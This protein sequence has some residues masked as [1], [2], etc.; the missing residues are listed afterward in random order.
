MEV[1]KM[2]IKGVVGK[3]IS[4]LT[5]FC[6]VISSCVINFFDITDNGI[7]VFEVNAADYSVSATVGIESKV[8]D[9]SA[10]SE[11]TT[12]TNMIT[13]MYGSVASSYFYKGYKK[14]YMVFHEGNKLYI[15][16]YNTSLKKLSS[17]TIDDELSLFGGFYSGEKYNFI[18]YGKSYSSTDKETYRVVKYDKNFNKIASLSI[19]GDKTYTSKPFKVCTSSFSE[20][21]N[22]LIIYTARLR[23]DGHQ[24]NITLR[25]NEEDMTISDEYDGAASYPVHHSGH[26]FRSIIKTDT[27][28]SEIYASLTDR[29][30]CCGVSVIK[31]NRDGYM[32]TPGISNV[33]YTEIEHPEYDPYSNIN[34]TDAEVNGLV[35]TDNSYV[36]TGVFYDNVFVGAVDKTTG[37][38]SKTMLT[39]Y[40]EYSEYGLAQESKLVQ[41]NRNESI[42]LWQ[43]IVD[44]IFSVHYAKVDAKGEI[45][46][47]IKTAFN[48]L[49]SD[50]QPIYDEG[51]IR[52]FTIVNGENTL[53]TISDTMFEGTFEALGSK[54]V[55]ADNIW[56]GT[57]DT[58][59]YN[60]SKN[61]FNISTAEQLAGLSEL[62]N[63]GNDMNGKRFVLTCDIYLNADEG[64]QVFTPIASVSSGVQ[65]SGIFDGNG[66][67]IYRLYRV[68]SDDSTEGGLFGTVGEYGVI[69]NLIIDQSYVRQDAGA[70]AA[71][72]Y[73]TIMFCE[74]M[75]LVAGTI[76]EGDNYVG[77]IVG[78]TYGMVYGC[79]NK[80]R[81]IGY[82]G[83]AGG[84]SGYVKTV[85]GCVKACY[86]SG[87]VSS[88][89][90]AAG[91]IIGQIGH[92]GTVEDCF[93]IGTILD[94]VTASST[95]NFAK[96]VGGIAGGIYDGYLVNC[97]ST[98]TLTKNKYYFNS[99]DPLCG[100]SYNRWGNNMCFDCYSLHNSNYGT[101][102]TLEEMLSDGFINKL[103]SVT[104]F[105]ETR[106]NDMWVKGHFL[107][108]TIAQKADE[109]N[110]HKYYP[111]ACVYK[112]EEH[113]GEDHFGYAKTKFSSN[114]ERIATVDDEGNITYHGGVGTVTIT[115]TIPETEVS[116]K[117]VHNF[118]F[119]KYG[120]AFK[121]EYETLVK[122]KTL[123]LSVEKNYNNTPSG[124]LSFSSDD[125]SIVTVSSTGLVKAISK[126]L[127]TITATHG[128][129]KT[130]CLIY[131][132]DGSSVYTSGK[133]GTNL[134]YSLSTDGTLTFTG[135]G[136][137][138]SAPWT[139]Y[140]R[141]IK[142]VSFSNKITNIYKNAFSGCTLLEEVSIPS[143]VKIV[144]M[145][146]FY[147]CK[148]LKNV[149]ISNG[150]ETIDDNAFQNSGLST[151]TLPKSI[152]TLG[153]HAFAECSYLREII[154][155][156]MCDSVYIGFASDAT[157]KNV[158]RI[159]GVAGTDANSLADSYKVDFIPLSNKD[160]TVSINSSELTINKYIGTSG[161]III[162]SKID[163]VTVSG[164]K[165]DCF[166]GN[167]KITSI[168]IPNTI[169]SKI[170]FKNCKNLKSVQLSEKMTTISDNMFY[171]CSSLNSITI[172]KDTTEIGTNAFYGC[173]SLTSVSIPDKVKSI[174][175]YAFYNCKKI[176][177]I[178][179]PESVTNF[180]KYAFSG[181]DQLKCLIIP[182]KLESISVYGLVNKSFTTIYGNSDVIG[183]AC[184]DFSFLSNISYFTIPTKKTT[185][186]N[187][188]IT[189][190]GYLPPD[191]TMTAS[192]SN[193]IYTIKFLN[194][195]KEIE[196]CGEITVSIPNSEKNKFVVEIYSDEEEQY[197]A[198]T[199]SSDTYTFTTQAKNFKFADALKGDTNGDGT[200][201]IADALMISRYDAGLITLDNTQIAVSD[202]NSDGSA[203]I[204]DALM[205]ARYDA[206]LI[207]GL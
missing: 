117:E 148:S 179:I 3:A 157:M 50:C 79:A 60:N 13:D 194:G 104:D 71:I 133:C 198:S 4:Y 189:V 129:Y 112:S 5:A 82:Y 94:S 106:L 207:N 191:T 28:G 74:N 161:T 64:N 84:I 152:K 40:N 139:D 32:S 170:S 136:E 96:Y 121:N 164:I 138:T 18:V 141:F 102:I 61:E 88:G 81:V 29:D 193:G 38:I 168:S 23:L 57:Y 35:I 149:L 199:Y 63:A 36:V 98:H 200:A 165:T 156:S 154:C 176:R 126:G 122:G 39:N 195:G 65:F 155:E 52:W 145:S 107:P 27:D 56:N 99:N 89:G 101:T 69:K 205:I 137:M 123:Q 190:T 203:D 185:L 150:T 181:C 188:G 206:G 197:T 180:G 51:T 42:V 173:N 15:D 143:S 108:V 31:L 45:K 47:K 160:Y 174:G 147:G 20:R 130:T 163:G 142:K 34:E 109:L 177:N 171:G 53:Y 151:V 66:Y 125:T 78:E 166:M 192:K 196:P 70:F 43:T 169:S 33:I 134:R 8:I 97:Y 111:T 91:G 46:G 9:S 201:D 54:I 172:P 128:S 175:E 119:T 178:S 114:N 44:G 68:E 41:I 26:I 182:A 77:G 115:M 22:I 167:Q 2:K 90:F 187:N 25:I 113:I 159:Y 80:G 59:W 140:N 131:V 11:L 72:N 204:A 48:A 55:D 7:G 49:L 58:N 120:I 127:A 100:D 67:T 132:T 184:N 93:N 75:G 110:I 202:V 76:A 1:F 95:T 183:R 135:S 73:G 146:A 19:D 153:Y 24:S 124:N 86:N 162:P 17:K 62:V 116:A 103:N 85:K 158:E 37:T 118:K 6:L 10:S 105:Y 21:D 16:I 12:A 186:T 92:I 14:Y 30:P 87:C 144:E 83:W